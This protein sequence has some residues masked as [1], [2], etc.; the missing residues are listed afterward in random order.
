MNSKFL[1]NFFIFLF[2]VMIS[3]SCDTEKERINDCANIN[4]SFEANSDE[5]MYLI[6]DFNNWQLNKPMSYDYNSK[7][8]KTSRVLTQG[9]H[10]Y[11]FHSK[12][13]KKQ[14]FDP[15]NP[16]TMYA[17]G[18][19]NSRL[20]VE[21]CSHPKLN[22]KSLKI[23]PSN[24]A[25]DLEVEYKG[26]KAID[27]KESRIYLNGELTKDFS[28]KNNRFYFSKSG[29]S[30]GKYTYLL[31]VRDKSGFAAKS[32]FVPI[33]LENKKFAWK[34]ASI[35]Q[36]FTDRFKNGDTSND[37]PVPDVHKK[38][39]WQGGD[40]AGI[41]QKI[42]DN[43]FTD[44]GIN[45]IWISS[46]IL[47]TKKAG[48][49]MGGDTRY[50]SA[51]H[52]YWPVATGY[53]DYRKLDYDSPLEDHFGTD[54]E[55]KSLV[56]K[57]HKKGIRVLFDVIPNHAHTDSY[58]WQNYNNNAWFHLQE[59][60]SPYIC[61]WEMPIICWFNRY[62]ADIDHKNVEASM[63][64]I[65]HLLWLAKEYNIDGFR[66]D[67][68]R[69]MIT[70]FTET[71]NYYIK[72]E[73]ETTGIQFYTIG[74]NFTS[75]MES[76]L[77]FDVI[78][79][80]LG[81]NRLIGLFNF[82][83]FHEISR[84]FFL[85]NE[86]LIEFENFLQKNIDKFQKDY[87]EDAIMG[88]FLGNHDLARAISVANM[89]FDENETN[90]GHLANTRVWSNEVVVP[91]NPLSY[92]KL[93]MAQTIML[94]LADIPIIYQ[95]DE[96]GF[97]GAND[98]DNR[99]MMTFDS[100]LSDLQKDTL[101]KFKKILKTRN[102]HSSAKVREFTTLVLN[103]DLWAYYKKDKLNNNYMI[104]IV[105]RGENS[106]IT[107]PLNDLNIENNTSLLNIFNNN[108]YEVKNNQIKLSIKQM[109]TIILIKN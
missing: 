105:N 64:V 18:I 22:V 93:T 1:F 78:G 31:K 81:E 21:N 79:E 100:E 29:L 76:E 61:G 59:D 66:I 72:E 87:Y 39:N 27:L 109:E 20:V 8:W 108:T 70:E 86:T 40:Y 43:Y 73:L 80:Y 30:E 45:T 49:G 6:G 71:L 52:S 77:A 67:A 48:K 106:D 89:D 10:A 85:Q 69:L 28:Y 57:A 19:K 63:F 51:Y 84:T 35:Y 26:I 44:L 15:N 41:I 82:P 55:L 101:E 47:N 104:V 53:N 23:N 16:L 90:G 13:N 83:L 38:A 42:D 91:I 75:E 33:W 98:P 58:I 11:L 7:S 60:G 62:L 17:N 56:N 25:Y 92:K 65:E 95:G 99:R 88:N 37:N 12:K 103:K 46:P 9:N 4:F 2:L 24:S 34:N 94:S 54:K 5:E 96:F 3:Y 74:E 14:F 68:V 107:L 50:Y 32:L 36:I 102:N 97:P